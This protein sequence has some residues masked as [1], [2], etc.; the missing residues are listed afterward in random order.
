M[1]HRR[2]LHIHP[3]PSV[4]PHTVP[5]TPH[6]SQHSPSNPPLHRTPYLLL[7]THPLHRRPYLL[8]HPSPTLRHCHCL[9]LHTHPQPSATAHRPSYPTPSAPL[10]RKFIF[11]A[12]ADQML[13]DPVQV[14]FIFT[15]L[16]ETLAEEN[17]AADSDDDSTSLEEVRHLSVSLVDLSS[18]LSGRVS[19]T[20]LFRLLPSASLLMSS[21]SFCLAS[22]CPSASFSH[23]ASL[24]TPPLWESFSNDSISPDSFCF[25]SFVFSLIPCSYCLASIVLFPFPSILLLCLLSH[26]L[27]ILSSFHLSWFPSVHRLL[28]LLWTTGRLCRR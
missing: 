28:T 2:P 16:M 26:S 6:P 3:Q 12:T 11:V 27:L 22:I 10:H 23:S 19:L 4:P 17:A 24:L 20:I 18:S 7:H 9:L 14:E 5:P 8:L 21:L 1:L 15:M 13:R 25:S